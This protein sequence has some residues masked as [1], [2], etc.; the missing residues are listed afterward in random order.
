MQHSLV[1]L[2]SD[3]RKTLTEE[4]F[5]IPLVGSPVSVLVVEVDGVCRERNSSRSARISSDHR[6]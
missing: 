6:P 2:H 4:K 1:N 5:D 3:E